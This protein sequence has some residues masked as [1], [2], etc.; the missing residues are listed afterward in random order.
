L[1]S[2][3]VSS[4]DNKRLQVITPYTGHRKKTNTAYTTYSL[5]NIKIANEPEVIFQSKS[6]KK[7]I[8]AIDEYVAGNEN[9]IAKKAAYIIRDTVK[10]IGTETIKPANFGIFYDNFQH[11]LSGGTGHTMKICMQNSIPMIDQQ[12]WFS[13]LK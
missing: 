4:V 10:V 5:E 1:F 8:Q 3:G 11:P 7:F 12:V 9:L 2:N 13:W 6:N